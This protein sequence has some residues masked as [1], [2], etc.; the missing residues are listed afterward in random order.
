MKNPRTASPSPFL[1]A[2]SKSWKRK[3]YKITEK[4]DNW[5]HRREYKKD[6]HC[7]FS[8][9]VDEMRLGVELLVVHFVLRAWFR[10]AAPVDVPR[11]ELVVVFFVKS[12]AVHV[13]PGNIII[14]EAIYF[15]LTRYLSW[16]RSN[17]RCFWLANRPL[18][19]NFWSSTHPQFR[20]LRL[21]FLKERN[22]FRFY[23]LF[24]NLRRLIGDWRT[25][26]LQVSFQLSPWSF[27]KLKIGRQT[28][29]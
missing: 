8:I 23:Y 21:S 27:F 16:R 12:V 29:I 25:P 24:M 15:W 11:V 6:S 1:R 20:F 18:H 13:H 22:K 9:P 7:V 14:F 10:V 19:H 2:V 4:I 17:V 3:K 28:R 5:I 26:L